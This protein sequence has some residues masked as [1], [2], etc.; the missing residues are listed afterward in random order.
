MAVVLTEQSKFSE[1]IKM[2]KQSLAR[3]LHI[4]GGEDHPDIA[5]TYVGIGALLLKQN[6]LDDALQMFDRVIEVCNRLGPGRDYRKILAKALLN[7]AVIRQKQGDLEASTEL[8]EESLAIHVEVLGEMHPEAAEAYQNIAAIYGIQD[9][10]DDAIHFAYKA[11]QIRRKELGMDHPYTIDCLRY[12][13]ERK[14][15]KAA[16]INMKGLTLA[17][18]GGDYADAVKLFLE[19]LEIYMEMGCEVHPVT[20]SVYENMAAAYISADRLEEAVAA[21]A[22]ALKIYRR[23]L[24]DEHDV[25]KKRMEEHRSL[26]KRFLENRS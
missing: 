1:A 14:F 7:Q 17:K 15:C 19:A 20:A 9:R 24:G 21:S 22:D 18:A 8:F 6:R 2:N 16:A 25:T 23:K 11:L 26:L 5:G 4:H 10:H 13:L 12:Y 3:K